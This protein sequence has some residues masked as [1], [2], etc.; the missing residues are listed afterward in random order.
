MTI[1]YQKNRE[2]YKVSTNKIKKQLFERKAKT[3]IL[4]AKEDKIMNTEILFKIVSK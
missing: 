1:A 4:L 3:N 2:A